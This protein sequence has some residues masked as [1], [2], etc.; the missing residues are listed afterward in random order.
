MCSFYNS[1]HLTATVFFYHRIVFP[2][3]DQVKV[4]VPNGNVEVH[5]NKLKHV[6]APEPSEKTL[7]EQSRLS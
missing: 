3:V 5:Y 7:G 4:L 2:L 1:N 6:D